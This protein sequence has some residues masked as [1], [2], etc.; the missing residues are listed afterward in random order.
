MV[1]VAGAACVLAGVIGWFEQR[2]YLERRYENTSPRLELASTL[3]WARDVRD[4]KIAVGGIRGVFN[5]YPL[6][7][8]DLSNEVQ[9]LGIRGPH[10]AWLRIPTCEKWRR[11]VNGGG[12]THVVTTYDPFHPGRL[13][14]TREALWTR[15]DDAAR[16]VLSDGPVNVFEITG[17]MDP[18][19]CAGLPQLTESELNGDSVNA[20]PLANQPPGTGPLN[21]RLRRA[22]QG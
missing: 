12:Y 14:D 9:W 6:Y 18:A 16:K 7:G 10:D 22:L 21:R 5:Q 3:R 19:A 8:T 13:T 17:R 20:E 2:H 15:E 11:A 4:A 1:T